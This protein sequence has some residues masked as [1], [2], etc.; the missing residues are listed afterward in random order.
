MINCHEMWAGC[1]SPTIRAKL[2]N[3]T[4][5]ARFSKVV[6]TK[7]VYLLKL[8]RA[9]PHVCTANDWDNHAKAGKCLSISW[10]TCCKNHCKMSEPKTSKNAVLL[11]N[12]KNDDFLLI[13]KKTY[14]FLLNNKKNIDLNFY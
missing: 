4:I 13:N 10:K 3:M 9:R 8:R 7:K 11:I 14:I 12:K 1:F 6:I 5:H 2:V